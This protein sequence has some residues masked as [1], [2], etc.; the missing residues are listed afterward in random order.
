MRV[1]VCG[2]RYWSDREYVYEQLDKFHAVVPITALIQGLATG[3]DIQAHDWAKDRGV[4]LP[5]SVPGKEGFPADWNGDY[6]FKPPE[7]PRRAAGNLRN[8]QMID[9]GKPDFGI[10]FH[11]NLAESSGTRDMTEKLTKAKIPWINL[12]GR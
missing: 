2:S 7:V 12:K 3:A 10:A 1:L 6:G 4:E 11:E 9:E 5:E 8:Q